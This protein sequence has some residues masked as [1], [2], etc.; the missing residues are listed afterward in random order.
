M[1]GERRKQ[2]GSRCNPMLKSAGLIRKYA[3]FIYNR[4]GASGLLSST[5][6][7]FCQELGFRYLLLEMSNVWLLLGSFKQRVLSYLI[8]IMQTRVLMNKSKSYLKIKTTYFATYIN[9]KQCRY[10]R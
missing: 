7:Q 2:L 4:M 5:F 1:T 9:I 6:S 10:W 3:W 8:D